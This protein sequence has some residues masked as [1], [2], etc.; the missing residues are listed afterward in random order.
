MA[1]YTGCS[2]S[3][4]KII[5]GKQHV[6][7]IPTSLCFLLTLPEGL[8]SVTL[9]GTA[10]WAHRVSKG[11]QESGSTEGKNQ[12]QAAPR[13]ARQELIYTAQGKLAEVMGPDLLTFFPKNK[14]L[15]QLPCCILCCE[16]KLSVMGLE[17]VG[18]LP[19]LSGG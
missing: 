13:P 1:K 2:C 17:I 14:D 3:I 18:I 11:V 10:P 19:Y 4:L 6:R 16:T 5:S 8:P 9:P 7:F 15:Q 12:H